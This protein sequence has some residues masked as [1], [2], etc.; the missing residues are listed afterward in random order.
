MKIAKRILALF[1]VLVALQGC[2]LAPAID[3]FKKLGVTAPDREKLLAERIRSFNDAMSSGA[4]GEAEHL[5]LPENRLALERELRRLRKSEKVVDTRIESV[6]FF[7]DSYKAKV[8]VTVRSYKVP[9]YVV[10]ERLEEQD[11]H[12]TVSTGWLLAARR[13]ID[14]AQS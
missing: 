10:N 3:S 12:F 4:A 14:E 1:V 13:V 6:G 8:E 7:E 11:W 2:F 5:V 9:F